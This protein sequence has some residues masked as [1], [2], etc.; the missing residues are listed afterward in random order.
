MTNAGLIHGTPYGT[1]EQSLS[2]V[3]GISI[4]YSRYDKTTK[5]NKNPITKYL[6]GNNITKMNS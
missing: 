5:P 2:V 6:F 4:E 1:L 3:P